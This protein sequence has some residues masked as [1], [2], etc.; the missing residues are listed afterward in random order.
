MLKFYVFCLLIKLKLFA[1]QKDVDFSLYPKIENFH[2]PEGYQ[3]VKG[4]E[5]QNYKPNRKFNEFTIQTKQQLNFQT[6]SYSFPF[7]FNPNPAINQQV[8]QS[9]NYVP[10]HPLPQP[11]NPVPPIQMNGSPNL[12]FP[13]ISSTR[14][15]INHETPIDNWRRTP[16]SI[17][18]KILRMQN[19]IF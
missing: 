6:P 7:Y 13:V 16:P 4:F 5:P 17:N 1:L 18:L 12:N 8:H 2:P 10:S 9:N 19:F 15:I 11:N 14:E 3:P